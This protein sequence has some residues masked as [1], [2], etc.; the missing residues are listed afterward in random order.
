MEILVKLILN[1]SSTL[2][3]IDLIVWK[4]EMLDEKTIV[5]AGLK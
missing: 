3:K 4:F 2:F 1:Q 5:R